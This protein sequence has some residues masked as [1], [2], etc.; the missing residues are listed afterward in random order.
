MATSYQPH[1]SP[2]P[3]SCFLTS[4]GPHRAQCMPDYVSDKQP[5]PLSPYF[6]SK[7]APGQG[8]LGYTY[9]SYPITVAFYAIDAPIYSH[10]RFQLNV[11][12]G[13]SSFRLSSIK[14][15]HSAT[16]FFNRILFRGQFYFSIKNR[17]LLELHFYTGILRQLKA[18]KPSL[19]NRDHPVQLVTGR[20]GFNPSEGIVDGAR[21]FI[22]FT[23]L[24]CSSVYPRYCAS[25]GGRPEALLVNGISP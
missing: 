4:A 7:Y 24:V 13:E 9:I 16:L 5:R 1:P 18:G 2:T 25:T 6:T 10:R 19:I 8:W 22:P 14:Q 23:E 12:L 15:N 11:I 21:T 3:A 17:L 20:W